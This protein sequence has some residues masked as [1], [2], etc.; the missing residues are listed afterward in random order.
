MSFYLLSKCRAFNVFAAS[1]LS[2]TQPN[3][4]ILTLE[5]TTD[6]EASDYKLEDE[7]VFD[8]A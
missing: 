8:F 7:F 3:P 6:A 5:V 1:K 4:N 2:N